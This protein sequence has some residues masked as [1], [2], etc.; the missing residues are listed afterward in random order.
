VPSLSQLLRTIRLAITG[1][2]RVRLVS[3]AQ[4]PTEAGPFTIHVFDDA[5]DGHTHVALVRGDLGTGENVLARL[6]SACLTG[7]I[8]HSARCDCGPQL[9]RAMD[10]IAKEGR[11]VI[12]YLNQEGRGIGIANK[13]RAYALQDQGYDTVEAN[14]RLGFDADLRDYRSAVL[15]LH[16]LGVRS[17]RLLSNNPLKLA[18]FDSGTLQVSER[19]PIE[20]EPS[21]SSRRY[22]QTKKDKLGH[23]LSL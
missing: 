17:V 1:Q 7:D 18:A 10:L 11:G 19:I 12:L 2:A 6:H 23:Q 16:E 5:H 21:D 22:L 9:Q 14:H 4:L 8:F 13:I 15:M 20:I 3:S